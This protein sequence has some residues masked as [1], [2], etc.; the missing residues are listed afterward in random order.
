MSRTSAVLLIAALVGAGLSQPAATRDR[1]SK[2]ASHATS[3]LTVSSA[4]PFETL[5]AQGMEK[6]HHDMA[7]ARPT[8]I[9]DRD[10]LRAMI[11]HHQGA[12]DMARIVLLHTQD[13]RIRNLA[14]S[15]ITEQQYEIGL[16][17]GMLDST[18]ERAGPAE[19][20]RK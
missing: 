5:M 1:H 11:P 12:I 2:N 20:P 9:P 13:P 14:Q 18:S 6:M 16:M 19:E 3:E 17:R 10:F 7:A 8:G 15:I 4:V